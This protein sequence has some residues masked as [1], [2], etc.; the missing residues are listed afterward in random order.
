MN[1]FMF[2]II[3][4][5]LVASDTIYQG[6]NE[7]YPY[8]FN[9]YVASYVFWVFLHYTTSHLYS[10]YCA[11]WSFY[12]FTLFP[13]NAITPWCKGMTWIM[14]KGT[15]IMEDLFLIIGTY[16]A[17]IFVKYIKFKN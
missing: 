11:N 8:I 16:F 5:Q 7:V 1:H 3:K 17:M 14:H 15:H 9:Y 13:L 4:M 10:Y 12:G 2:F 6:L